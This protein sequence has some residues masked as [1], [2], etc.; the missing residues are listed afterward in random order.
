MQPHLRN[1]EREREREIPLLTREM[2]FLGLEMSDL[3]G[4]RS[5]S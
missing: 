3:E 2:L 1:L 5:R 4:R